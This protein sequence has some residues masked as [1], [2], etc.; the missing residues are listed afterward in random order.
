[1]EPY[2][3]GE[4]YQCVPHVFKLYGS[5]GPVAPPDGEPDHSLPEHPHLLR[6][7]VVGEDSH[8]REVPHRV[9]FKHNFHWVGEKCVVTVTDPLIT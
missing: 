9:K 6:E 7:H 4:L 5:A 3:S 1:M 2:L 8:W